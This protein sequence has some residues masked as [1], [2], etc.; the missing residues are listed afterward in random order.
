MSQ[1]IRE[2]N[3]AQEQGMNIVVMGSMNDPKFIGDATSKS[4][5]FIDQIEVE[6]PAQN[7]EARNEIV[8]Y[9]IKKKGIKL[10]GDAEEQK[11]IK[12]QKKRKFFLQVL[13]F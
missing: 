4:F 13:I 8:N 11:Q 5:K 1:L 12:D 7:K 9:Y 2:M 10:A 6:S 3:K